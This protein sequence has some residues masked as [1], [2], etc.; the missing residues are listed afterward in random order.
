MCTPPESDFLFICTQ[1]D[2]ITFNY[3][4]KLTCYCL[5]IVKKNNIVITSQNNASISKYGGGFR[6]KREYP[7]CIIEVKHFPTVFKKIEKNKKKNDGKT[8]I[9]TQNQFSTKLIIFLWFS[10]FYEICQK[11]E[12]L[13]RN[14]NDLSQTILNICYFSKNTLKFHHVDKIIFLA[15]LKYLKIVYKVPHMHNFFLLA[16]EVQ[17]LTKIRQNHEYLQI[18]LPLKHKPPFSPTTGNYILG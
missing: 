14:D 9:F 4:K 5:N 2:I 10:N 11:R 3:A 7:W 17:M 8:G 16:F 15:L 1:R 13:Q 12:N 18:I 6:C